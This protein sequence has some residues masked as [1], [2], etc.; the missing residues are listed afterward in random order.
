MYLKQPSDYSPG[1]LSKKQLPSGNACRR[2][3]IFIKVSRS[4]P[5][6]PTAFCNMLPASLPKITPPDVPPSELRSS[7]VF[8]KKGVLKNFAKSTG[9]RLNLL[10]NKAC[11]I[12]Q[13]SRFSQQPFLRT[14]LSDCFQRQ[15]SGDVR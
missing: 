12:F 2:N 3:C 10:F 6:T 14:P 7:H 9:K 1:M 11:E 5:R 4:Q 15:S 8:Y 13:N